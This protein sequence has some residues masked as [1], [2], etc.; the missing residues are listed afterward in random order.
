MRL[1]IIYRRLVI[2]LFTLYVG[3]GRSRKRNMKRLIT[4]QYTTLCEYSSIIR[5]SIDVLDL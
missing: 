1:K 5:E 3:T 2:E 4:V